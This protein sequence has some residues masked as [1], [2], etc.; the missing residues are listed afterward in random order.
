MKEIIEKLNGE[1]SNQAYQRGINQLTQKGCRFSN[2]WEVIN[3]FETLDELKRKIIYSVHHNRVDKS[4]KLGAKLLKARG[5]KKSAISEMLYTQAIQFF[6]NE[7]N[8]KVELLKHVREGN[9]QRHH[10][11][12]D[13]V[14]DILEPTLIQ[15]EKLP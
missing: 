5:K 13:F 15:I 2:I 14:V 9:L 4:L 10:K 3:T 7:Y 8:L 1:I 11:I 12:S 6:K